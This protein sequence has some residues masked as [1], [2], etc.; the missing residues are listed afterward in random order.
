ML[1]HENASAEVYENVVAPDII[2]DVASAILAEAA[3][4]NV[5]IDRVIILKDIA[6][7]RRIIIPEGLNEV[8]VQLWT[9]WII[10]IWIWA[11]GDSATRYSIGV[12]PYS[13]Y[14]SIFNI[15]N[16]QIWAGVVAA[17]TTAHDTVQQVPSVAGY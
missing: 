10:V 8:R 9:A 12:S 15:V 13:K 16:K 11:V 1:S 3:K 14:I 4:V 17:T 2:M 5:I 7:R 6:N